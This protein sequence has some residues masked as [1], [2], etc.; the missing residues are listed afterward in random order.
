MRKPRKKIK[1]IKCKLMCKNYLFC[2]G[3]GYTEIISKGLIPKFCERKF[4]YK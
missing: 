1:K 3:T 4:K 2:F